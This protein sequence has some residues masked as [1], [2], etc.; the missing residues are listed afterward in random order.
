M[1]LIH[2][3]LYTSI[4]VA[5]YLIS[6]LICLLWIKFGYRKMFTPETTDDIRQL[7]EIGITP[8]VNSFPAFALSVFYIGKYVII[9]IVLGWKALGIA[10]KKVVDLFYKVVV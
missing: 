9:L 1:N 3:H 6:T 4:A 7:V 2:H 10:S 5:T 8:A